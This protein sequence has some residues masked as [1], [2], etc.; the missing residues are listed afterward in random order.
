MATHRLE[1]S[2]ETV[3]WGYF[4]A[5]LP[6][7]LTIDSGDT[8][9]ITTVSG[10]LGCLPKPDSGLTVPPALQAIHDKVQPKLGGPHILTGPVAV[11]GAKAG[12]VLEVRIKAIEL[13]QD[14]GYNT[15]RPLAGA[16]PDD[17]KTFRQIHIPL[18]KKRMI[19]KLPW[20][21]DLDLKPFFGIMAV[22]PPAAWGMINSPPPR[23]NGGNMDNKEL[24]AGTTL[25][26]PIH[27][28]GALFSCGDGHGAQGDGEVCI[29]AIETGLV[30]TFELIVRD[31]MSRWN[32]RWPRR[33]P[34]S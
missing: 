1:A 30:G 27:T 15:I 19:G 5:K 11:R 32:G 16:L 13:H 6:P 33:R 4:D 26:L 10:T 31:D 21:L 14:W 22:A 2:P 12:Q 28:D 3:H 20:G 7:Q 24:V 25:Y 34:M 8:V 29:T 9:T 23:R 18:D 17:F